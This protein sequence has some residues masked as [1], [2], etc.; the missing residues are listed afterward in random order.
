[1]SVN[2]Q[3]MRQNLLLV[4]LVL[5]LL[6][7]AAAGCGLD[8]VESDLATVELRVSGNDSLNLAQR[9]VAGE[10]AV[11]V[12]NV[13]SEDI[14]V[15]VMADVIDGLHFQ[16]GVEQVISVDQRRASRAAIPMRPDEVRTV[17][18]EFAL[19]EK[20]DPGTYYIAIKVLVPAKHDSAQA[21]VEIN[22]INQ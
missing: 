21:N 6:A 22:V 4:L 20:V 14:A 16:E 9:N 12:K 17:F 13:S 3:F 2:R 18:F 10:L 1:M 5:G 7:L 8:A 15:D 19:D 11:E